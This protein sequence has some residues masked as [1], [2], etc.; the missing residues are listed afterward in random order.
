MIHGVEWRTWS[1]II[2]VNAQKVLKVSRI[3]RLFLNC[4][5]N[6]NNQCFNIKN[7]VFVAVV[8]VISFTFVSKLKKKI[9]TEICSFSA[10]AFSLCFL[11]QM[12]LV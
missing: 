2:P 9:D 4:G 5:E 1:W 10:F 8:V 12:L 11:L 3:F 7:S 6:E